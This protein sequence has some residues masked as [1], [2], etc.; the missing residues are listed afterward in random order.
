[1]MLAHFLGINPS[2]E[3]YAFQCIIQKKKRKKKELK[4]HSQ[5]ENVDFYMCL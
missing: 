2:V 1:M 4:I 3:K 5:Q